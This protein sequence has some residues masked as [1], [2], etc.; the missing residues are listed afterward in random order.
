MQPF[1]AVGLRLKEY[2]HRVRIASHAQHRSFVEQFG[3]EFY[4]LGGDSQ[5]LADFAVQ[6]KGWL[7]LGTGFA[8]S[9]R[10]HKSLCLPQ[11]IMQSWTKAAHMP[12]RGCITDQQVARYTDLFQRT[13]S[14][15]AHGSI[16]SAAS[17]SKSSTLSVMLAVKRA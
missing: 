8:A 3:M 15:S 5:V 2:G 1:L 16:F 6:S 4:P 7:F 10:L 14:T 11:C 17:A 13:F 9:I 12:S